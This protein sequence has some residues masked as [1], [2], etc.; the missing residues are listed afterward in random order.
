[1][2]PAPP[3]PAPPAFLPILAYAHKV[4]ATSCELHSLAACTTRASS[5]PSA[6]SPGFLSILAYAHNAGGHMPTREKPSMWVQAGPACGAQ[7]S[8]ALFVLLSFLLIR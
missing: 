8:F 5:A 7:A 2:H 1:M 6:R 3:T 4:L